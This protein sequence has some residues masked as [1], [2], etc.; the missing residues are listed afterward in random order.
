M[1]R[2]KTS[3]KTAQAGS[4]VFGNLVFLLV[5]GYGIYV[6][7]QYVP[8]AIES[9]TLDSV[10]NTITDTQLG[11]PVLST[12]DAE[13]KVSELLNI[14]EMNDMKKNFKYSSTADS[15]YVDLTYQRELDLLFMDKA[16]NFNKS[17]TV[18]KPRSF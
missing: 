17:V 16:L 4:S 18:P 3:R 11:N 15:V 1:S 2:S 8:I 13:K 7:V 6:G 10:F 9:S 12:G 14:N 5:I